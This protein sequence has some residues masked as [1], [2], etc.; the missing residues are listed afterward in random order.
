MIV[1][2]LFKLE[3]IKPDW[4]YLWYIEI[5]EIRCLAVFHTVLPEMSVDQLTLKCHSKNKTVIVVIIVMFCEN[6]MVKYHSA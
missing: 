4:Y 3:K 6:Y 1:F 5:C 2:V